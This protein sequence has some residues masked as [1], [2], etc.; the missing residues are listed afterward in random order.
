MPEN[1]DLLRELLAVQRETLG[2][3]QAI[4]RLLEQQASCEV[5]LGRAAEA[6][7]A[8]HGISPET[9]TEAPL[10]VLDALKR[11]NRR[12]RE[13]FQGNNRW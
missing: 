11:K 4:R 13:Q 9:H 8:T 5:P 6:A 7:L 2:E 1:T 10:R 3:L 12:K